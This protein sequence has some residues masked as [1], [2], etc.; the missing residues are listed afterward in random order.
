MPSLKVG[1]IDIDLASILSPQILLV[2][3]ELRI[4]RAVGEEEVQRLEERNHDTK[5]SWD[6]VGVETIFANRSFR[7]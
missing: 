4:Q 7:A 3:C 1:R 6:K 5:W 2:V